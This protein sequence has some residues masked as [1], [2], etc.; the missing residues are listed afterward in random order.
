MTTT[1]QTTLKKIAKTRELLLSLCILSG[2]F[3]HL[4]T[5][6]ILITCFCLWQ[7]LG[8]RH[9]YGQERAWGSLSKLH[10]KLKPFSFQGRCPLTPPGAL[11]RT[12][13]KISRHPI[14]PSYNLLFDTSQ[15]NTSNDIPSLLS[16][17]DISWLALEEDTAAE[18]T[19]S[20]ILAFLPSEMLSKQMAYLFIAVILIIRLYDGRGVIYDL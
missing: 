14:C 8:Q 4:T 11:K 5:N 13:D 10:K 19:D 20:T 17:E 9:K 7:S 2:N 3:L 6:R 18:A 12:L 15:C 1:V 16:S